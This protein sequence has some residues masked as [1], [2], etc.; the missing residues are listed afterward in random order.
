MYLVPFEDSVLCNLEHQLVQLLISRR[1]KRPIVGASLLARHRRLHPLGRREGGK[2]RR[3]RCG[4]GEASCLFT[5]MQIYLNFTTGHLR[6]P[7]KAQPARLCAHRCLRVT[8]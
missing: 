5:F 3:E 1:A 7:V 6:M 4:D 8:C 2:G